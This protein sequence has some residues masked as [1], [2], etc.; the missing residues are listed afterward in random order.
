MMIKNIFSGDH[1]KSKVYFKGKHSATQGWIAGE[2]G[3]M[4]LTTNKRTYHRIQKSLVN[5]LPETFTSNFN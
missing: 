5:Q 1:M 4:K 2:F 3:D